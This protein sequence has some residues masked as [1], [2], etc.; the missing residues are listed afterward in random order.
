MNASQATPGVPA[1]RERAH[2]V[3]DADGSILHIHHSVE[4]EGG[5]IHAESPEERAL[6]LAGSPAGA[7]V[8]EVDPAEVNRRGDK[9]VDV[10]SGRLLFG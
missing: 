5:A 2:V 3:H 9:R 10:A 7:R 1:S 8:I 6:R 4:F